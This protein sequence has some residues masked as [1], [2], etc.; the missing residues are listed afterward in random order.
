MA[1]S[2]EPGRHGD[3]EFGTTP[4][5]IHLAA[6]RFGARAA[7]IEGELQ[8]TYAELPGQVERVARGLIALGIKPSDPV[9]IWAPN[10]WEWVVAAL[11]I[12]SVGGVLLPINTRFK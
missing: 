1:I 5:L 12:H 8:I 2:Q 3:L 9:A 11:A 10:C 7:L 6:A 4:R